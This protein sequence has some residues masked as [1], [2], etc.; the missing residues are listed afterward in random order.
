M[1][2]RFEIYAPLQEFRWSGSNHE[3]LAGLRI[4]RLDDI[5]DLRGLEATLAEEERRSMSSVSHWLV[6][7]WKENT[8]PSPAETMNLVLLA[9]WLVKPTKT[10]VAFRFQLGNEAAAAE[11]SRPRVLDRFAWVSGATHNAFGDSDLQLATTYCQ[12]L[13]DVCRPRGRLNDALILT[14]TG[15]W[16]HQWQVA[17]ICHAAAAEALLTY[18]TAPRITDRLATS[19]ACLVETQTPLRDTAYREFRA[20]YSARSD[21]MH[22]RTHKVVPSERLPL[23]VRFQNLLRTL[24]SVVLASPHLIAVLEDSDAQRKAYFAPLTSGY[25]PPEGDR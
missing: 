6:F 8:D 15:C 19:Y 18:S 13:H 16:S 1:T 23:L 21:I 20:L 17:L 22:G 24:W 10:H 12:T 14:A 4:K 7:D 11:K 5:P 9:L 3:L 25:T 2:R